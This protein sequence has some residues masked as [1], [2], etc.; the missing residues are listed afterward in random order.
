MDNNKHLFIKDYYTANRLRLICYSQKCGMCHEDAEDIVQDAFLQL[1]NSER[2]L[3]DNTLPALMHSIVSNKIK[4]YRRHQ[5]LIAQHEHYIK[6]IGN[7]CEDGMSVVS[8]HE[9]EMWLQK[10]MARL[11]SKIC[12]VFRMN[13]E[14]G[15]K[16]A[17]IALC[18]NIKYKIAE[19]RLGIARKK[20]R[21]YMAAMCL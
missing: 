12:R 21:Q 3:D 8:M 17:E 19:N 11:D 5:A 6:K 10:S 16:V 2:I 7:T 14:D 18:L 9:T 13:I 15:K 20:V 1:M 4:D